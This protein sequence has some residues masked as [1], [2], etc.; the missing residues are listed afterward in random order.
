M[1]DCIIPGL[2][3]L[4]HQAGMRCHPAH[5]LLAPLTAIDPLRQVFV[6]HASISLSLKLMR[7]GCDTAADA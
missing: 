3:V 6:Q 4:L 1:L 2:T 5:P 7:D